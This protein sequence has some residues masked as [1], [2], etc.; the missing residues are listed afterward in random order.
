MANS[1]VTVSMLLSYLLG[2]YDIMGC[3]FQEL[4]V[5]F[6]SSL[7]RTYEIMNII[8]GS[9]HSFFCVLDNIHVS[10]CNYK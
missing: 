5:F 2:I 6:V 4:A 9:L 10:T 7:F 3:T 8:S 1:V